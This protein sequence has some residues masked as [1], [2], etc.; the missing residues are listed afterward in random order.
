MHL[1]TENVKIHL[2]PEKGVETSVVLKTTDSPYTRNK[3]E[4]GEDYD[5]EIGKPTLPLNI[6][7]PK[8]A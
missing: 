3:P 1:N 2:P 4:S 7:T 8:S 6:I 5:P